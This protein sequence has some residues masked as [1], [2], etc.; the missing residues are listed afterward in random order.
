MIET[1]KGENERSLIDPIYNK[2][3][4]G[5][6]RAI[7]STEFYE[8]FMD[9]LARA[10]NEIQFS[11]RKLVKIVDPEWVE[12]IELALDAIQNII[13]SPRNVIKEEDLIVNVAH[14]KKSTAETVRH[15]AQHS[16]LV[17]NFDEGRGEVRPS[18]LMQRF[19][20]ETF[21]LY[22]NRLVFTAMEHAYHFVKIR[23]DALFEAMSDEFG[24]KLKLKSDMES[25]T[26]QVHMDMYLHIKKIDSA[27]ETD[28]KNGE[29]FARISRIYRVLGVFMSSTFAQNMCKLN[30]V[31]GTVVKTN[32]LKRNKDYKDVLKLWEFLRGYDDIGYTIKVVEQNPEVNERLQE[33]IYRNILFNYLVLKG[34][35]DEEEDREIPTK[36]KRRKRKIKPKF[37]REIVEELTEDYDLPDV[38]V[39]KILIEELTKEQLLQEEKDEQLRLVEEQQARKKAEEERIKAE[40]EAEE[41]RKRAEEEAEAER[42]RK[43]KE[44]EEQRIRQERMEREAEERRRSRIFVGELEYFKANVDEKIEL[45]QKTAQLYLD[46]NIESFEDFVSL[47]EAEEQQKKDEAAQE[48][49]RKKEERERIR[50]AQEQAVINELNMYLKEITYFTSNISNRLKLRTKQEEQLRADAEAREKARQKRLAKI[51]GKE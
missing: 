16:S 10:N 32:I 31:K 1:E 6:T 15:L 34:Y 44:A 51:S 18:K 24:A 12:A 41:A 5:V 39:R 29:I 28:R 19:R 50:E 17:E 26:E 43:E 20:E 48:K 27:L 8:F 4:K 13:S 33:D 30:R 40:K 49:Q 42:I 35:L 38:E 3:V 7:G 25:A 37:I 23:H 14:A 21:G 2:F 22:E 9:S 11:N 47:M 45:R 46:K 36:P